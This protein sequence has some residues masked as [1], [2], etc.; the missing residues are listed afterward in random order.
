MA[1]L[2]PEHAQDEHLFEQLAALT[3]L[4]CQEFKARYGYLAELPRE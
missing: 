2:K 3:D 4:S 1:R